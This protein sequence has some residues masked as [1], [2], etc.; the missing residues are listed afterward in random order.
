MASRSLSMR[1]G[2]VLGIA[3]LALAVS[4][5]VAMGKEIT[6]G[7]GGGGAATP[8]P[9]TT[10]APCATI[11]DVLARAKKG[12]GETIGIDLAFSIVSCSTSAESL[13]YEA[14]MVGTTTG[15]TYRVLPATATGVI[16]AG[17]KLV[18]A[19][20]NPNLPWNT[21][22]TVTITVRDALTGGVLATQKVFTGTPVHKV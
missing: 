11:A 2:R 9:A 10:A 20:D 7:G 4:A 5:P 13:T 21:G 15:I 1:L 6:S 16:A 8:P 14:V 18:T 22:M 12:S 3:A 17:K 19:W